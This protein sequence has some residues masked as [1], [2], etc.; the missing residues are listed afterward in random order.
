MVKTAIVYWGYLPAFCTPSF[1]SSLSTTERRS[2]ISDPASQN[3]IHI[4]TSTSNIAGYII[5]EAAIL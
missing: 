4:T 2:S 1:S 3:T 5:F